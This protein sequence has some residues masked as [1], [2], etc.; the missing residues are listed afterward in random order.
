[1]A[2]LVGFSLIFLLAARYRVRCMDN[3]LRK[4][5]Q[6][7]RFTLWTAVACND[8]WRRVF[9]Q[10][11]SA[12]FLLPSPVGVPVIRSGGRVIATRRAVECLFTLRQNIRLSHG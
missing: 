1:M 10:R 2:L 6:N 7:S 12:F 3:S 8:F 11:G 5:L 4:V 9:E